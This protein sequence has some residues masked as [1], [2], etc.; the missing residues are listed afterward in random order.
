MAIPAMTSNAAVRKPRKTGWLVLL[1]YILLYAATLSGMSRWG[2]FDPSDALGVAVILGGGFSLLAWLL[3]I[4]V[5]PLSYTVNQPARELSSLLLY[6]L[7]LMA[8]VTWGFDAV[9][10]IFPADP[11]QAFA[12]LLAKLAIFVAVPAWIMRS[13]YGYRWRQVAPASFRTGHLLVAAGM[14][15]VL[16]LF[17]AIVGRGLRDLRSAH[18][19]TG[20]LVLGVPIAFLWLALE[21][22]IVEEFFFRC[23]LQSR[24]A[25]RLRSEVG[26][27]VIMALL[28]GLVHAPGL[29]LRTNLTQED[30]AVHPSLFMAVGY[31]IV[32]TSVAG[33]FLGVLWARTRNLAVVVI[34]HAAAD[35]LPDLLPTLRSLHILR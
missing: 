26:G 10:R 14:S 3:T 9:R 12:M 22:G 31:S 5:T 17:Q 11:V 32:I 18:L 29:Y 24:L 23:L 1:A 19:P 6:L 7:P 20:L 15:F 4:R 21:A 30:L 25:A 35:L 8:F 33:F 13:R 16:L 27:I 28:F 34:V 2:H